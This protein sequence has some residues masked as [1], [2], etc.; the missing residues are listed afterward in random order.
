MYRVSKSIRDL[1][2]RTGIAYQSL[3]VA[4]QGMSV[5]SA[6][7]GVGALEGRVARGLRLLDAVRMVSMS[8]TKLT[9]Q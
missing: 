5:V 4:V 7:L 3:H 1:G 8:D 6:E 9:V 2:M